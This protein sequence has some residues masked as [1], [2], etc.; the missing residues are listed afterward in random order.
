MSDIIDR[1][2]AID[3]VDKLSDEPIG[4]LEAAIDA[5]VDLPSAQPEITEEQAIEHLQSTGW[6]QNHDREMYDMGLKKQLADN[7]GS[8]DSLLPSAQPD[9]DR[10][11]AELSKAYNVPGLPKEAIGIIG[12]LMVSLDEPSAQSEPHY[13]EWCTDCKEYNQERHCCPRWNKVIRQTVED[14]KSADRERRTDD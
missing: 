12:D 1:Q 2:A 5:L 9:T 11:Y 14:L 7:S 3:S 8:Y 13:D 6:M 4:Y 10:I